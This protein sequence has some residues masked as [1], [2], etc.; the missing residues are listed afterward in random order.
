MYIYTSLTVRV[1][2]YL[3]MYI[4]KSL[5]P[6]YD[7]KI[8]EYMNR[9][10]LP[11]PDSVE[12]ECDFLLRRAKGT[13]EMFKYT[14]WWLT[15]NVENSKVMGM[16]EAF[17]YLVE[18]YYMKG[19]AFWL[20]SEELTKYTDRAM[21]IAPNVIGNLAPEGR[22]PAGAESQLHPAGILRSILRALP[23]RATGTGL[24]VQGGA[25]KTRR[26]SIYHSH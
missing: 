25:E 11:W 9:L 24:I 14:L 1:G 20:T 16:D 10:T 5:T 22:E 2:I 26:K 17:V 18:N 7:A 8:D 19:D 13:K 12:K 15:R 21:K 23:E 3:T 6:I 4:H